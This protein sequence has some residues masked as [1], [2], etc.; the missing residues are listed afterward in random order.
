MNIVENG[1][2]SVCAGG[3]L[4]D[5]MGLG[6]TVQICAF[7]AKWK[8]WKDSSAEKRRLN[9]G[10]FQLNPYGFLYLTDKPCRPLRILLVLPLSLMSQ[11]EKELRK[12]FILKY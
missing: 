8:E 7:L 6:K 2:T 1:I 3:I 10:L 5:E 9:G 4:A 11:W 12:W